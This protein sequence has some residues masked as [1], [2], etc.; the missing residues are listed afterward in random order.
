MSKLLTAALCGLSLWA[1]AGAAAA[2][3][4]YPQI[5]DQDD[6]FLL[7]KDTMT[8]SGSIVTAQVIDLYPEPKTLQDGDHTV[9]VAYMV[10]TFDFDCGPTK[11]IRNPS[12]VFFDRNGQQVARDDQVRDWEAFDSLWLPFICQGGPPVAP[13]HYPSVKAA[14]EAFA[15]WRAAN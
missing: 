5:V 6:M 12:T 7:D 15:A 4:L 13:E 14:S 11:R 9:E 8:R 10:F 3:D 2:T 1:A